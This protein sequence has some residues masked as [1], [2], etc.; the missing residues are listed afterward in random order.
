MV[1]Y[2]IGESS[3]IKDRAKSVHVYVDGRRM[4]KMFSVPNEIRGSI[5]GVQTSDNA[6][7]P[8]MFA[9]IRTTGMDYPPF[10]IVLPCSGYTSSDYLDEDTPFNDTPADSDEIGTIS[11]RIFLVESWRIWGNS[12]SM[13]YKIQ[14]HPPAVINE[15]TKKAGG[16]CVSYVYGP[17]KH[18]N[19]QFNM[20][21]LGDEQPRR[22]TNYS[23]SVYNSQK[24][25][26]VFEFRYRSMAILQALEIIPSPKREA[27]PI[28]D[29]EDEHILPPPKRQKGEQNE[30]DIRSMQVRIN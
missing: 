10:P 14:D 16:H 9:D 6:I 17:L 4:Q 22:S 21:S 25:D 20:R 26:L 2:E 19:T 12:S 1:S 29:V 27:P 11:V 18:L 3:V 8:F 13:K 28:I 23:K 30:D 5:R 24:P 7:R 15:R